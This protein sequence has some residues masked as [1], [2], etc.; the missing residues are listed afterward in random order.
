V[1]VQ[2]RPGLLS[3]GDP[4]RLFLVEESVEV[5]APVSVVEGKRVAGEDP[6]QPGIPVE[7]LLGRAAIARPEPAAPISGCRGTRGSQ[8]GVVLERP[9]LS[10]HRGI[11]GVLGHLDH[12]DEELPGLLLPLEDVRDQ[13]E[14]E[15][16][17][18]P[19]S[20]AGPATPGPRPFPLPRTI[21]CS[22]ALLASQP[23]AP[24]PAPVWQCRQSSPRPAPPAPAVI[25]WTSASWH[26]RQF[27]RTI[28]RSRGVISI[29]SLKFWRV[30]ATECRTPWSALATHF[31]TPSCG[32][33]HSTQVAVCR[34]PLF[35]R[36]RTAGS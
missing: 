2:A 4:P 27:A 5:A 30:K 35:S 28:S 8:I 29:G 10:P 31:A 22:P 17:D 12:P 24:C 9:V 18:P 26:R 6:P 34:C 19:R 21:G 20:R 11:H 25:A 32:R 3:L 36:R 33:W 1:A 15:H 13:G 23:P 7:L 14:Q 16:G